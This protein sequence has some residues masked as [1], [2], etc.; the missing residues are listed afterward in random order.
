MGMLDIIKEI[1]NGVYKT[2]IL[3]AL[4]NAAAVYLISYFIF[5][6]IMLPALYI[7]STLALIYFIYDLI[8]STKKDPLLMVEEKYPEINEELR[9]VKDNL[10]QKNELVEELKKEVTHKV[11]KHVDIGDFLNFRKITSRV[12]ILFFMSFLII[13]IAS[14]NVRLLGVND[15]IDLS[16][17]F[18]MDLGSKI[19]KDANEKLEVVAGDN[20]LKDRF[21]KLARTVGVG[22]GDTES[23]EI[24]GESEIAQLGD[25]KVNIQI[26]PTEYE[27]SIEDYQKPEKQNF[28]SNSLSEDEVFLEKGYALEEN[29]PLEKQDIVKRYFQELSKS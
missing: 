25:N 14:L 26:K 20:E 22:G 6:I 29:I 11:K 7:S 18:L 16:G 23:G 27:L 24:F 4:L 19:I 12:L 10:S 5:M 9:T 3:K 8:K 2:I 28:I 15:I 1:K 21:R 17:D 13:L